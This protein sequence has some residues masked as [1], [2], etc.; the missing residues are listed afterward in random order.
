M[1][2]TWVADIQ[3]ECILGLDFL[4]LHGCMV[5]FGDNV[6]H[7]SSKEI[8]LQKMGT[9]SI[10]QLKAYHTVF[11]TTVRLPTHSDCVAKVAELSQVR[12]N[13]RCRNLTDWTQ[14]LHYRACLLEECG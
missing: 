1:H 8:P 14:L 4:E 2:P 12:R 3:D 9:C 7:I 5:D 6:L 11:D 10:A 13:G